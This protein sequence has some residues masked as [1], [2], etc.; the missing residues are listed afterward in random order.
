MK[1]TIVV[2][3][4]MALCAPVWAR[5]N[6]W[7]TD[8]GN[9]QFGVVAGKD[10]ATVS[11][12]WQPKDQF[13]WGFRLSPILTG[14]ADENGSRWDTALMGIG[15]EFPAAAIESMFPSLPVQGKLK[16]GIGADYDMK[17]KK[18]YIPISAIIDIK[19]TDDM[20]FRFCKPITELNTGDSVSALNW[21][22]GC[23][24]RW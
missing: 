17:G 1:K 14:A 13:R 4:V 15:V 11:W 12:M 22:L 3:A 20:D 10:M 19:I 7:G 2:L 8:P 18:V 9:K 5:T 23:V 6:I 21:Q 16:L 24:I